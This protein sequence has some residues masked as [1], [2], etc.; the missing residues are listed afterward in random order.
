MYKRKSIYSSKRVKERKKHFVLYSLCALCALL[1][2]VG[3]LAWLSHSSNV[4]ITR[5]EVL[6]ARTLS[7]EDIKNFAS[8][9]LSGAHAFFFPKANAFLYPRRKIQEGLLD[10]YPELISVNVS[11]DGFKTLAITLL[12][13][14]SEAWWCGEELFTEE[15]ASEK[16]CY[17]V[18]ESGVVFD[19]AEEFQEHALELYGALSKEAV[20]GRFTEKKPLGFY[21][22]ERGA[23]AELMVFAEKL[24]AYGLSPETLIKREEGDYAFIFAN[25]SSIIFDNNTKKDILMIHLN[26]ALETGQISKEDFSSP[27]SP[28]EYLDLR[29][30]N[31]VYY[32]RE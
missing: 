14:S 11:R 3:G 28:L 18:D 19:D 26:T 32:K 21:F 9:Y 5:V 15:N 7:A 4:M 31:R 23:Y 10:A 25:G 2:F 22:A 12:E 30:E 17:A 13:R 8:L 29:F 20:R 24:R 16:K 6:G 27:F 1:L